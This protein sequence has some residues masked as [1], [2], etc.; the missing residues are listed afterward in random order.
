MECGKLCHRIRISSR[1]GEFGYEFVV[2]VKILF[3]YSHY[4]LL[5]FSFFLFLGGFHNLWLQSLESL[6]VELTRTHYLLFFFF[7][8]I[9]NYKRLETLTFAEIYS[10]RYTN[11]Y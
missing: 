6:P 7:F 2:V 8:L 3:S 9:F 10:L 11:N 4:H 1:C 5:F